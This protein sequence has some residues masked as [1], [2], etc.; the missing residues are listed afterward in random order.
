MDVK[1]TTVNEKNEVVKEE[2]VKTDVKI[3]KGYDIKFSYAFDVSEYMQKQNSCKKCIICFVRAKTEKAILLEELFGYRRKMWFPKSHISLTPQIHCNF[4][5]FEKTEKQHID[6][7][8]Q[9][10]SDKPYPIERDFGFNPLG[11]E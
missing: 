3:T 5:K 8:N 6:G 1:I 2:E 4:I 7:F 9:N 10:R 11:D